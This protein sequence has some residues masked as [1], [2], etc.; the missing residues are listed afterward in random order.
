MIPK[1]FSSVFSAGKFV[2]LMPNWWVRGIPIKQQLNRWYQGLFDRGG[3]YV[4]RMQRMWHQA[5]HRRHDCSAWWT[6]WRI[7]EYSHKA[8]TYRYVRCDISGNGRSARGALIRQHA[9][10]S[11]DGAHEEHEQ[12]GEQKLFPIKGIPHQPEKG[13]PLTPSLVTLSLHKNSLSL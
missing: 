12:L 9:V 1:I 10:S 11:T 3:P 8:L 4:P 2:Q 13:N 7:E 6:T 5:M